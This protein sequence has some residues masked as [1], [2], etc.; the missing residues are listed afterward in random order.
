MEKRAFQEKWEAVFRQMRGYK[1]GFVSV[2]L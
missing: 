2:L 1:K